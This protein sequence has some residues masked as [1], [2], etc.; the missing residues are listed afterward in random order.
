MANSKTDIESEIEAESGNT[1]AKYTSVIYVHGMGSQR[2]YE[3]TSRL[4]DAV[5][6]YLGNA[7]RQRGEKLGYLTKIK[8]RI[9]PHRIQTGKTV[10][11]IR[12]KHLHPDEQ[13]HWEV[14]EV[15]VYEAYWAPI[16]AGQK[17]A[18]AVAKWILRQSFRPFQALRT[19]W[20]ERQR[21][22]RAALAEMFETPAK[23]PTD[24]RPEDFDKLLALYAGFD[25]YEAMRELPEGSFDSF[26]TWIGT[27]YAKRPD[28]AK[29]LQ[30]L[31]G[32]WHRHYRAGER[33]NLFFILTIL[34]ALVVAGGAMIWSV[35]LLLKLLTGMALPG[36]GGLLIGGIL[37]D[38]FSPTVSTA[39]GLVLSGVMAVGLGKFLT[40]Y[41]GDVEVWATYEETD[42]KHVSRDRVIRETCDVMAHALADTRCERAIVISHSLGTSVAHDA[43]LALARQNR[44]LN[45]GD[46]ISGPVD[47]RKISHFVTIASPIDKI[48]Y[49]FE[50]YRTAFHRY[51]RVV[52]DLRGDI[53]DVPFSRNRKPYIHWINFWDQAD[54]ISGPLHSPIARDN[55]R[56]RVDNVHV[57]NLHAPD[58]GGSH[59]AYF[60]NRFVIGKLFEMIYQN[61]HGFAEAP[62]REDGEGYDLEQTLIGPGEP[63]G[64][65]R[66]FMAAALALPWVG[67]SY[68]VFEFVGADVPARFALGAAVAL[69]VGLVISILVKRKRGSRDAI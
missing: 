20:R 4:I 27:E 47:L 14:P 2:R 37:R 63:R 9:E 33:R 32:A 19:P 64:L 39:A 21:I 53:G 15:R 17:S 35:L 6:A 24:T 30:A 58:P 34:A 50:S 38:Q 59:S 12:T 25:G 1:E 57:A 3:E 56:N 16:M 51:T 62:L 48:N 67:L 60:S 10:T 49:F 29:R 69:A 44:A 52:E 46:A 45:P 42:D 61:R 28:T 26:E 23:W 13:K 54:I 41:M 66:V 36:E 43:V 31:A 8:P 40:D 22:R 11:Y 68:L 55:M 18:I 7:Y 5:D 65:H